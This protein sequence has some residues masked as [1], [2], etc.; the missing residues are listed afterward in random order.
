MPGRSV[1]LFV[2]LPPTLLTLSLYPIR[3]QGE[4]A[5]QIFSLCP[6][7]ILSLYP[8]A[9]LPITCNLFSRQLGEKCPADQA[10]AGSI[11]DDGI[12]D[13]NIKDDGIKDDGI[14]HGALKGGIKDE[15]LK[16]GIVEQRD[17]FTCILKRERKT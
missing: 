10:L 3:Q 7:L 2:P 4:N 11:K 9:G 13:D 6:P 16:G 17:G 1:V 15:A 5:W 8:N 12:N 14:N